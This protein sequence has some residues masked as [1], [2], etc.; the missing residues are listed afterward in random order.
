M[1]SSDEKITNIETMAAVTSDK[2]WLVNIM[3]YYLSDYNPAIT[4]Y[5][6]DIVE[7]LV[8]LLIDY[9]D[10][11]WSAY[12]D[13]STGEVDLKTLV[14][15]NSQSRYMIDAA[16][17]MRVAT[18]NEV[19]E[20]IFNV[21]DDVEIGLINDPETKL[22]DSKYKFI[23]LFLW[24]VTGLWRYYLKAGFTAEFDKSGLVGTEIKYIANI[25]IILSRMC[26]LLRE[27]GY[28]SS[29]IKTL[30]SIKRLG[31]YKYPTY[32]NDEI[33]PE[34][35]IV[36]VVNQVSRLMPKNKTRI[37]FEASDILKKSGGNVSK[38]TTENKLVLRKCLYEIR[39]PKADA[40]VTS[41]RTMKE[42]K[43]LCEEIRQAVINKKLRSNDFAVK[44]ASTIMRSGY[45]R[46]SEKQ[47]GVLVEAINKLRVAENREKQ[48]NILAKAIKAQQ[49]NQSKNQSE[50]SEN[51]S[52]AGSGFNLAS[53]SDLL[54]KGMM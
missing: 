7:K 37:M 45:I 43:D 44:V 38:M 32:A 16:N 41:N 30:K 29:V 47:K 10:S 52:D 1:V 17:G 36:F 31:T 33:E 54:G 50:A 8:N 12:F 49:D 35:K 20:A 13:I 19:N 28:Y 11:S 23:L 27:E 18:V 5:Q 24:S 9:Y 25:N 6:A 3:L 15:Y 26:E 21:I 48:A 42:I 4:M 34:E 51:Q 2:P 53:M 39:N 22:E 46:C 14:E 40:E